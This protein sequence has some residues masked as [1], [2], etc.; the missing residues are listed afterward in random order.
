[1]ED[2]LS[3]TSEAMTHT[4][5]FNSREIFERRKQVCLGYSV[6]YNDKTETYTIKVFAVQNRRTPALL[7]KLQM[8]RAEWEVFYK[9]VDLRWE[10][11]SELGDDE[12]CDGNED[13]Y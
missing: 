10:S 5:W 1:M 2:L 13:N 9:H 7:G 6:R 11:V 3:N 4:Q 8:K 12:E